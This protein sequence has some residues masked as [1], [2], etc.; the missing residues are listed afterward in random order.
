MILRHEL[1]LQSVLEAFQNIGDTFTNGERFQYI[2]YSYPCARN[3]WLAES[4]LGI[5]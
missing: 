1:S 2:A 5:Y 3:A 4:N